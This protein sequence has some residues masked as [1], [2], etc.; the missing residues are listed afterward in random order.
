MTF[1]IITIFHV[2]I[3]FQWFSSAVPY[4]LLLF[5]VKTSRIIYFHS[6][7]FMQEGSNVNSLACDSSHRQ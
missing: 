1:E 4:H 2:I 6:V 7:A 5:V 3:I